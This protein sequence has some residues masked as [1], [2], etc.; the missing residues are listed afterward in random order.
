LFEDEEDEFLDLNEAEEIL[1]QL[2]KEN[3]SEYERIADL[4]DGVRA[5]K[6]STLKGQFVFCEASYPERETSKGFQQ[7]F[8]LDANGALVSKDIPKI[9]G[10][11]KCSP[12]LKS[13]P[14]L[15]TQHYECGTRCFAN[16]CAAVP[17]SLLWQNG[18]R[19]RSPDEVCNHFGARM[20][21]HP[22]GDTVIEG[23]HVVDDAGVVLR[24]GDFM[25]VVSADVE[26][27][28]AAALDRHP[29]HFSTAVYRFILK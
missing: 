7:L 21:A 11:I 20:V 28:P 29:L 3:P 1:R 16:L 23:P 12:E 10:A 26:I 13:Q 9:L 2:R 27:C 19:L 22:C 15:F 4:R 5:A 18:H 17:M 25:H 8:L 6:T 14:L 24:I